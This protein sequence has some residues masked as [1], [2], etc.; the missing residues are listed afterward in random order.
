[1]LVVARDVSP[2]SLNKIKKLLET[3]KDEAADE[4]RLAESGVDR[5]YVLH[6]AAPTPLGADAGSVSASSS[7]RT[8]AARSSP[9][10][11][12]AATALANAFT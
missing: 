10:R 4:E 2:K 1:M 7:S 6:G 5:R 8:R 3:V 11:L 12:K 9:A